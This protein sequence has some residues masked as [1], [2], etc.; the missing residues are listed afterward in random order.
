MFDV[1]R[2][3]VSDLQKNRTRPFQSLQIAAMAV[4]H[5]RSYKKTVFFFIVVKVYFP[6]LR[7][8]DKRPSDDGVVAHALNRLRKR[9]QY[10]HDPVG[11]TRRDVSTA[12]NLRNTARASDGCGDVTCPQIVT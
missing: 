3:A 8:D 10:D 1:I 12:A 5:P 4:E 7:H 6:T 2:R 9:C 11:R